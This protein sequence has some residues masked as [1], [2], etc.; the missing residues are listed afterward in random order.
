MQLFRGATAAEVL[1]V[2]LDAGEEVL[3][4]LARLISDAGIAAGTIVSGTGTL[5][6]V[7]L[8][9][10]ATLTWPSATYAV[11]K[12]GAIQIISAQGHITSVGVEL[13]VSVT[14]RNES[15][16]GRVM[17]GSRV[18]H[19][20]EFI[21]LR[22]GNTRWTRVPHPD[23]GVPL[24]QAVTAVPVSAPITLMG[25]P[26]DP[27]AVALVPVGLLK[28]HMCLP[29]AKTGDT[30]VVAMADPTNPFALD[31]LREATGLRVQAVGVPQRELM[32][33][34]QQVLAG[35]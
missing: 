8:E 31:D 1:A 7:A 24:L 30:L 13:L 15:F 26:V 34:L 19:T 32:G 6:H 10:P 33:A 20:A 22:A 9:V 16:S 2:R 18:L 5:E 17:N 21:V 12:Q 35:R 11:E 25:R 27:A 4:S 28:K 29:V 3:D 14:K 23:T